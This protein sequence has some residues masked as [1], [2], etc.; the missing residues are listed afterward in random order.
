MSKFDEFLTY[1]ALE[2]AATHHNG[3]IDKAGM[4]YI[5]HVIRV[6]IR[7]GEKS[8]NKEE[9]LILTAIGFLHDIVEDTNMTIE[10]LKVQMN[11]EQVVETVRL[12]TR[13]KKQSYAQYIDLISHDYLA[14][15]VKLAD[16]EDHLENDNGYK[17]PQS[18]SLRYQAA[19]RR[20]LTCDTYTRNV[21]S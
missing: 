16:I 21:I 10:Q 20:L 4:P 19:K 17:L 2:L 6:G 15:L 14:I 8:K 7:A 9:K 1:K 13:K 11:N 12:L 18:L 5:E 3:Q